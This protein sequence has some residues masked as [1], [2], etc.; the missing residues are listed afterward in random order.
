[1]IHVEFLGP[2]AKEPIEIE[3]SSLQELSTKLKEDESLAPWLAKCAIAIN[4]EMVCQIDTP[5][6]DG[7]RVSIL[8]PVCGG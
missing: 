2:I 4:D 3:A 6:Q 7:D 8:P 5:L 1:M